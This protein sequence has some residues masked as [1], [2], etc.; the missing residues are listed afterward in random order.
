MV[1]F[2]GLLQCLSEADLFHFHSVYILENRPC[3]PNH[4][5][6]KLAR[7]TNSRQN[8]TKNQA[9][10][11]P[12]PQTNKNSLVRTCAFVLV[13]CCIEWVVAASQRRDTVWW[14]DGNTLV[15]T[16]LLG[17]SVKSL[18]F[19]ESSRATLITYYFQFWGV[20]GVRNHFI[21][22]EL[23]Q[24]DRIIP[25]STTDWLASHST[26]YWARQQHL[27]IVYSLCDFFPFS[28][29]SKVPSTCS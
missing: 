22:P 23:R 18:Q 20:I 27:G 1:K 4:S 10:T 29:L 7:E 14:N 11:T 3:F 8:K 16:D 13:Q 25:N 5:N 12:F 9:T 2:Q 21:L 26:T 19:L 24:Y 17:L 15:P 6:L 28:Q